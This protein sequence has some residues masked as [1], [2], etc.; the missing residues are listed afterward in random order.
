MANFFEIDDDNFIDLDRVKRISFELV[1]IVDTLVPWLTGTLRVYN[2]FNCKEEASRFA[3]EN[4]GSLS[5]VS[6]RVEIDGEEYF[7]TDNAHDKYEAL[8]LSMRK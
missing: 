1:Y 5:D 7:V 2:E 8:R 4:G 3:L 6:L